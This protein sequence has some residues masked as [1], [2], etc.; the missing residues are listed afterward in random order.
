M[1]GL[2][3]RRSWAVGAAAIALLGAAAPAMAADEEIQ[4]Y[5]DEMGDAGDIGLDIHSNYVL[6]GDPAPAYPGA[7][8][9]LHRLRITPEW[10]LGLGGGFEAGLY[11]P[12]MTVAPDGVLR[13]SGVKGRMKFIAPH[14][15]TG[16]FW[17]ANLEIG[18]VKYRLDQNPWNGE[19]KL[20]AGWR[21]DRWELAANA[22]IGFKVAGPVSAPA[23]LEIAS[24]ASY[25]VSDNLRL[26]VESY[27]GVGQFQALG[28]FGQSDQTTYLTIDA[29]LG[30]WDINAGIGKGYGA[31]S[32]T[33]VLKFVIGVPL[34]A[35]L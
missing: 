4:V 1:A 24:K 7:E 19:F 2:S 34:G 23:E 22:N 16:A 21:N 18:R 25:K 26:G 12:L 30:K 8:P 29:L 9:A 13:A 35:R 17:G 11:L 20:I 33:T 32:D 5:M 15:A 3:R 10:G 14:E 31:S 27:N 28:Q 6:A